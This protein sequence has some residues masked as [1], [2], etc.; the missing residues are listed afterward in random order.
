MTTQHNDAKLFRSK[1]HLLEFC[2]FLYLDF[3]NIYCY[4]DKIPEGD[5]SVQLNSN[6]FFKCK[7]NGSRPWYTM[8]LPPASRIFQDHEI[9]MRP[10]VP[11]LPASLTYL[12]LMILLTGESNLNVQSSRHV[13]VFT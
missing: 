12:R 2:P 10:L 7:C 5:T 8:Y 9:T 13:N 3:V 6:L 4:S 1:L 11:S